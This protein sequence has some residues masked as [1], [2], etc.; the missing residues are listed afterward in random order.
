MDPS[1][2]LLLLLVP[3]VL[4]SIRGSKQ[5]KAVARMQSELGPGA[6]V[7]TASGQFGRVTEVRADRVEIEVAQGV[8]TWWLR[9]AVART[10]D[11]PAPAVEAVDDLGAQ[12]P[13]DA[14]GPLGADLRDDDPADGS[15]RTA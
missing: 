12:R 8:R 4:L 7:M 14:A 3:L 2:V 11:A 9:Q 10:V 1:L 15:R 6:E 5:R 13:H